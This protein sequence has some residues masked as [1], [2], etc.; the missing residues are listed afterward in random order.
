MKSRS[1]KGQSSMC[2]FVNCL[3][4][5]PDRCDHPDENSIE[6][7]LFEIFFFLE[8]LASRLFCARFFLVCRFE[9]FAMVK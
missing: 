1:N 8:I 5:F 3:G 4:N 2:M 6:G 9:G 7:N